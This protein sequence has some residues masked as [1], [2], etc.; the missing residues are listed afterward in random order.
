MREGNNATSI[1][2]LGLVDTRMRCFVF[3]CGQIDASVMAISRAWYM[4]SFITF[5]EKRLVSLQYFMT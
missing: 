4:A 5:G 3:I 2:F 1:L